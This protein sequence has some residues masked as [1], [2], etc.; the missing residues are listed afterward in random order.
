M[1]PKTLSGASGFFLAGALLYFYGKGVLPL[2]EV[3]V[4]K[5]DFL[6]FAVYFLIGLVGVYLLSVA[7]QSAKKIGVLARAA[8]FLFGIPVLFY[9]LPPMKPAWDY[10]PHRLEMIGL[11]FLPVVAAGLGFLVLKSRRLA[12][13]ALAFI[14][15]VIAVYHAVLSVRLAIR[16][17]GALSGGM[18]STLTVALGIIVVSVVF[19][20]AGF[21]AFKNKK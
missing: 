13:L 3:Y 18:T 2:S 1:K 12:G 17:G 9:F 10:A 4:R 8:L 21:L 5:P 19:A 16:G 7:F 11:G 15:T 14:F 20:T 6:Y